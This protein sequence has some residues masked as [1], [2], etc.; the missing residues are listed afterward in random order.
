MANVVN[1]ALTRYADVENR[2]D[3]TKEQ[4]MVIIQKEI[5]ESTALELP[6]ME[7]NLP[8]IATIST[9]GTPVSYTHLLL[10][11]NMPPRLSSG[12][13]QL[14]ANYRL[15]SQAYSMPEPVSSRK[16]HG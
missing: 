3:Q 4:K 9:L 14:K 13:F 2:A 1:A 6:F 12:G 10:L 7:Q 11:R 5:E 15:P 8:V 16:K